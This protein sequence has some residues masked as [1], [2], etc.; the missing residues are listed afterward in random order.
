MEMSAILEERCFPADRF[1]FLASARSS[2][3]SI[4]FAGEDHTVRT[5]D[6]TALNGVDIA[7]F[8]AGSDVSRQIA[9]SAAARGTIV[10]DNSSAFRMD[11]DVPLVIPEINPQ[12]LAGHS[13]IIANPNCSTIIMLMAVWPLH[14]TNPVQRVIVSTYQA[15]SGAGAAA[16][17]ELREQASTILNGDTPKP[18][19]FNHPCAFNVFSHDTPIGEDGYNQE[20]RKMVDEARKILGH[21][22]LRVAATCVRVPVLRAHTEAIHVVCERPVELEDLRGALRSAPGVEVL[23]DRAANHFPMPIEVAGRDAVYI[24][25]IRHDSS[26]HDECGVAMLACGDQIRKGAALNAVQIAEHL[27]KSDA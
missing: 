7:L 9:R 3:R 22:G 16:M 14:R 25:R 11:P 6:E 12:A 23:D 13:G 27:L 24:G 15:A 17:D 20:E 1:S 10:I 21:D 18:V 4:H 8:S 19:V 26:H 5:L 2:G